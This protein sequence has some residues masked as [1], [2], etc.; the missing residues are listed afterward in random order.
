[1]LYRYIFISHAL[2]FILCMNQH[3][4]QITADIYLTAAAYLR[5]S[6]QLLLCLIDNHLFGNSH[7]RQQFQNQAVLQ[8]QKA[9]KQM[10]LLNLLISVLIGIFLTVL[11]RFH[12][13]LSK[14][15]NIHSCSSF[16]NMC[17]SC[18]SLFY[19]KYNTCC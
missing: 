18:I 5:K 3:L 8:S 12:R 10:L 14:F 19:T 17:I 2:R 7:F 13:L 6:R 16:R 4:V 1:M 11:Y 9:V 15:I